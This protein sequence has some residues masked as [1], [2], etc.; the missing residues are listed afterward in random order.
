[1]AASSASRHHSSCGPRQMSSSASVRLRSE[2]AGGSQN[3]AIGCRQPTDSGCTT[4]LFRSQSTESTATG[5]AQSS[6]RSH[7]R[8]GAR[9]GTPMET[10]AAAGAK[11]TNADRCR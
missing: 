11:K 2:V 7:S 6:L 4:G 3:S 5:V 8:T 1:M 10:S 9:R